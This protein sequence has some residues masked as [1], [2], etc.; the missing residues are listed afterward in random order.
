MQV[1]RRRILLANNKKKS[2]NSCTVLKAVGKKS[3]LRTFVRTAIASV[4]DNVGV[5]YPIKGKVNDPH[6]LALLVVG[7]H[8]FATTIPLR[9]AHRL[10][11][12]LLVL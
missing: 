5:S 2:I 1:G 11:F 8:S 3:T 9:R 10:L 12:L 4:L 6:F 7:E